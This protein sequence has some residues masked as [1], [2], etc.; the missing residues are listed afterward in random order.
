MLERLIMN[1]RV[2]KFLILFVACITAYY[3]VL[4]P[5]F[6]V[7]MVDSNNSHGLLVPLISLYLLWEKKLA[8][9]N[10]IQ[11]EAAGADDGGN[12]VVLVMLL[13][14]LLVYILF[15]IGHIAFVPRV[16]FVTSIVLLVWYY[17]GKGMFGIT[18]FPLL[19]LFFMIPIPVSLTSFVTFPLKTFATNIA[20]PIIKAVGIPILQEGNILTLASTT[21]EVAEACSGIRSFVSML[22]LG[23]LFA[24]FIKNNK[25]KRYFLFIVSPLIAVLGNVLRIAGTGILAHYYGGKVARGFIHEASGVLIFVFGFTVMFLLYQLMER[26]GKN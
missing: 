7:W 11:R 13:L 20:V 3:P 18:M 25:W 14:S 4:P 10:E 21:L 26:L 9:G 19:F 6:D 23:T 24:Y 2:Y 22:M 12:T 15:E 8:I 16:M 17:W 1:S 5:L